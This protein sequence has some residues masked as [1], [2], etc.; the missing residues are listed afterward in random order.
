MGLNYDAI[1]FLRSES[2]R[3]VDF[4][5][6]LTL[7]RQ[8]LYLDAL[9][10]H[11]CFGELPKERLPLADG[12]LHS[13]GAHSL[14]AMDASPYEGAS[15]IHD[16]NE[17]LPEEL[18]ARY[19]CVIDGGT[20]EHIF[21]FST[22]LK[23]CM[24]L[25]AADGRLILNTPVNNFTGHGFYQF[26]P[27]L[28]YSALSEENGFEVERMVMPYRGKWYQIGEP[29]TLR[30]RVEF[31]SS[32][33]TL[34]CVTARRIRVCP[35]FTKWPC[36]SDYSAMWNAKSG[37]DLGDKTGVKERLLRTIPALMKIRNVWRR[38]KSHRAAR[39]RKCEHLQEIR[40]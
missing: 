39:I 12:F 18:Q 38:C 15:L 32:S 23:S 5:R 6:T 31:M 35:I 25:V 3:G 2:R 26:S 20:L 10:Y 33:P 8:R 16:L 37:S 24:E 7:G 1:H 17:P 13:L 29:A 9:E 19:T 27:E 28:F 21:N 11:A 4:S 22:A 34:V 40:L 14:T 36:Q 30:R